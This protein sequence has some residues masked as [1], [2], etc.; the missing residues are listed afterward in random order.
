MN[1]SQQAVLRGG[2]ATSGETLLRIGMEVMI[3]HPQVGNCR[4]T[5]GAGAFTCVNLL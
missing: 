1:P 2:L 4:D 3:R 5:G